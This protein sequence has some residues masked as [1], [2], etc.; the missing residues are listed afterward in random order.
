MS[1][2]SRRGAEGAGNSA[3]DEC[4]HHSELLGCP[5]NPILPQACCKVLFCTEHTVEDGASILVA[6]AQLG[7]GAK[8]RRG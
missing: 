8:E 7:Q 5:V 3:P 2:L 1:Q 6:R 4:P